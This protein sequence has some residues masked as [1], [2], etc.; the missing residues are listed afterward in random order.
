MATARPWRETVARSSI[1]TRSSAIQPLPTPSLVAS[2]ATPTGSPSR[3]RA[4]ALTPPSARSLTTS[5]PT[6]LMTASSREPT[7]AGGRDHRSRRPAAGFTAD[8]VRMRRRRSVK[9]Q[10]RRTASPEVVY[11]VGNQVAEGALQSSQA[12]I[13]AVVRKGHCDRRL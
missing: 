4:C 10:R 9:W 6:D 1:S 5:P 13:K 7:S 8:F 11:S 3:A 2:C 12:R